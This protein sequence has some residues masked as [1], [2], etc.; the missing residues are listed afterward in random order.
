M[1]RMEFFANKFRSVKKSGG[2][3]PSLTN[4]LSKKRIDYDKVEA[5]LEVE[6]ELIQCI[7]CSVEGNGLRY[8]VPESLHRD[9]QALNMQAVQI[10]LYALPQE[11]FKVALKPLSRRK[12]SYFKNGWM[13]FQHSKSKALGNV[14]TA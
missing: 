7:K 5:L 4:M 12:Q 14:A 13:N 8:E 9:I 3:L 1:E 10:I 2:Q 11:Q 6:P